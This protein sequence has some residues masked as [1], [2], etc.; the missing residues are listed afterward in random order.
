MKNKKKIPFELIVRLLKKR[1][2]GSGTIMLRNFFNM[3][4]LFFKKNYYIQS[5]F[6]RL[7]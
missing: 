2:K 5:H 6:K 7:V 4:E 1:V 3:Y